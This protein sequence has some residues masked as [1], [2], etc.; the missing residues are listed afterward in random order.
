MALLLPAVGSVLGSEEGPYILRAGV[1]RESNVVRLG[2]S[3]PLA[4]I[5]PSVRI[6]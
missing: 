1:A 6:R 5:L 3:P 4:G 2:R